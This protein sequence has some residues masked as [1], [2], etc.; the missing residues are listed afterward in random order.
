MSTE[1]NK[2]IGSDIW[3]LCGKEY[4]F[5]IQITGTAHNVEKKNRYYNVSYLLFTV[6]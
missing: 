1:A 2:Q 3:T 4:N 6:T 5:K